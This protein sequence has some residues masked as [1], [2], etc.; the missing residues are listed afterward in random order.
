MTLSASFN[1]SA[2]AAQIIQ[3]ALEDIG[4]AVSGESIDSDDQSVALARLNDISKQWAFPSDG[5]PG[6]KVFLRK[7]IYLFLQKGTREYTVGP[8][9]TAKV[10][11]SYSQTTISAA[12]A[13]GQTTLSVVSTTGMNTSDII[14]IQLDDGTIQWTTISSTGAG[15]TVV[16]GAALTGAAAAG[17]IVFW[18]TTVVGF[19]PIDILTAVLRDE[20]TKDTP[21]NVCTRETFK[22]FEEEGNKTTQSDPIAVL[23]E[24]G[25]VNGK[26]T[27]DLTA[28]VVDKVIRMIALSPADDL[29]S[30]SDEVAYPQQWFAALE[31]ELARRCASI[32]EKVWTNERQANWEQATSIARGSNPSGYMGSHRAQD[33]DE[34]DPSL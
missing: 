10:T 8:T 21:I 1:Y 18:Y 31:W 28:K 14:G 24:P 2:T 34:S 3:R 4:V 16:V 23:Y 32:F 26:F 22:D 19:A 11:E 27:L 13:A 15:P 6:L 29:D 7:T 17:N 9:G 33:P 5:S 30:A 12:E 20:N 25:R